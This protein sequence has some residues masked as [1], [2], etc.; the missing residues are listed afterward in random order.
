MS[1]PAHNIHL[2]QRPAQGRAFLKRYPIYNYQHT[3]SS[4][5]WFDTASGDIAVRSEAEGRKI[6]NQYLGCFVAIYVDNPVVPIW[7]GLINRIT[8][9]AGNIAYTIGLDELAN[10]VDCVFIGATNNGGQTAIVDDTTSQTVYGIKEEQIEFGSDPTAGAATQRSRLISTILA[11]RAYPQSS[12]TQGQ[13]S[14]N[15]VHLE[16]IGIFHTLEWEK[17]FTALTAATSQ[18]NTRIATQMGLIAN[19]AT[20]FDNTNTTKIDVNTGTVPQQQ[21]GQSYWEHFQKIAE[22]GDTTNYW[23][24]GILPTD[25][26]TRTRALYYRQ[27]NSSILYHAQQAD[28]L[29]VRNIYGKVVNPWNVV[30]DC[31]IRITDVQIGSQGTLQNDPA[32]AYI[33]QVQYDANS[34]Q[35]QWLSADDTTAR[36]AF[37]LKRSWKPISRPFG[38]PLRILST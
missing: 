27:F 22:A 9:N 16:L 23:I 31:G 15:I 17:I 32:L 1:I 5:G 29:R 12:I 3:I 8:L 26:N 14:V 37:M 11:Q 35:V 13:G 10:R 36:A 28:A 21:R 38:A 6:L 2:Y 25:P 19:G 18:F 24:V 4:M 30:P 34:Q 20:F 33:Q 7:E